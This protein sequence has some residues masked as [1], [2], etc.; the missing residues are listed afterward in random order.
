MTQTCTLDVSRDGIVRTLADQ[1]TSKHTFLTEMLQNARRAGASRI[2]IHYKPA[3]NQ[4]VVRD[5]GT[6]TFDFSA[7]FCI[8]KSGWDDMT[9]IAERPFGIGAAAMLFAAS[10]VEI[11]SD[12][13]GVAFF[14]KDVLE[15]RPVEITDRH[16]HRGTEIRLMLDSDKYPATPDDLWE[17][18]CK[19]LVR[20]FPVP[21]FYQGKELPRPDALDSGLPFLE[22]D[23]GRTFLKDYESCGYPKFSWNCPALYFQ[24]LP[25]DQ[26]HS[27]SD[28]GIVHLDEQSFRPRVPDRAQLVDHRDQV[29][30]VREAV[31]QVFSSRLRDLHAQLDRLCFTERYWTLCGTLDCADLL[32]DAPLVASMLQRYDRP[33]YQLRTDEECEYLVDWD[34]DALPGADTHLICEI[35]DSTEDREPALSIYAIEQGYGVLRSEVPKTHP[36]WQRTI[37][38]QDYDISYTLEGETKPARFTGEYIWPNVV[39]CDRVR[40]ELSVQEDCELPILPV[41]TTDAYGFY[42]GID[43]LLVVPLKEED[44]RNLCQQV[45]NY[46]DE[47]DGWADKELDADD[48]DLWNLISSLRADSPEAYLNGLLRKLSIDPDLLK[49]RQ[50]I[51]SVG[52]ERHLVASLG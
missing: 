14:T 21:V 10:F 11:R 7:F 52:T 22:T 49:D 5:N 16:R 39:L 40:I 41:A 48:T 46:T 50:F 18:T 24:G 28:I 19:R 43:Q 25:I 15:F 45:A 13:K 3:L 31:K 6:A 37:D 26:D 32:S 20:G 44:S 51:V 29:A 12:D 38:L 34:G 2:D 4:L 36:A 30:R 8:G 9:Q 42:D 1:F 33:I 35:D 17:A 27:S 23:I 47:F